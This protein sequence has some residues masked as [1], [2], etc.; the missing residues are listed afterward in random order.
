MEKSQKKEIN[1]KLLQEI[2]NTHNEYQTYRDW[3]KYLNDQFRDKVVSYL[4]DKQDY[5]WNDTEQPH[6]VW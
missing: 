6:D 4:S 1:K 5:D 3:E 2:E